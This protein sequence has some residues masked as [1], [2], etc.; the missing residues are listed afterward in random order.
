MP[1]AIFTAMIVLALV[2]VV[3]PTRAAAFGAGNIPSLSELEDHAFRHGDIEDILAHIALSS[4]A[5][6]LIS[7][8][9]KGLDIKR[10]YFGN[11]LRDYS[12][13]I[14]VGALSKVN[15]QTLMT[16][17]T[18]LGFLAFN[19]V[20]EEF[21]VTEQRLG[22]YRAEEH[23][24]NP[25]GYPEDAQSYDSRLRGPVNPRELEIDPRTGLKNYIA[26]EQGGWAT[27]T[28][29]VRRSIEMSVQAARNNDQY[30]AFRCL[31]QALHTLEDYPAHSN[32]VELCLIELG[33]NR[34][35]PFVGESTAI[36]QG[37]NGPIYPVITGTFGAADFV[38]SLLG[39]AT[40]HAS[41]ASI[42]NV[43]AKL[44]EAESGRS[45]GDDELLNLL[46][47]VPGMDDFSR[48]IR[49]DERTR[50][51]P[52]A[53]PEQIRGEIWKWLVLRDQ[54][55]KKVDQI[56]ASIPGLEWLTEKISEAIQLFIWGKLEP[57]LRPMISEVVSK[58]QSAS[59]VIVGQD[60]QMEV[61]NNP[62]CTDP[63]HS[64][65]S[66]DHFDLYLNEPA[67]KVAKYI[68]QNVVPAVVAAWS[69]GNP[70]DAVRM[71]MEVFV[72]PADM[73]FQKS[74]FQM[75]MINVVREWA[76][77]N[78]DAINHLDKGSVMAGRNKKHPT[79]S[80][81]DMPPLSALPGQ[82]GLTQA[83]GRSGPGG[84]ASWQQ[85]AQQPQ[86]QQQQQQG[87]GQGQG[88]SG[89]SQA[90]TQSQY[91]EG[92]PSGGTAAPS[93]PVQPQHGQGYSGGGGFTGMSQQPPVQ[94]QYV[95]GYPGGGPQGGPGHHHGGGP[96]GGGGGPHHHHQQQNEGGY[97]GSGSNSYF[98][99]GP[100]PPQ[101]SNYFEGYPGGAPSNSYYQNPPQQGY[102]PPP[103]PP[104]PQ[105]YGFAPPPGPPPPQGY[106]GPGFAPPEPGPGQPH[107]YYGTA[108]PSQGPPAP[109][110]GYPGGYPGNYGR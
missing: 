13:A 22:C 104:P 33:Y 69:S 11:W 98:Q 86:Y 38:H 68:V 14:D 77:A 3:F 92:W 15:K 72:H 20:T 97:P 27:S 73:G 88:Y 34:V 75:G 59:S 30:E 93:R 9:F 99:S 52:N 85:P 54:I 64:V 19:Y 41:Q 4:G 107:G 16:L 32:F 37:R 50:A 42:T 62:R 1:S 35:F 23:I 8:K 49:S 12:Q 7:K 87:Y 74:Q 94:S 78:R 91:V 102:A 100:P 51:A 65:L 18:V 6:G 66:K 40:D 57:Y 90:P 43:N 55:V 5:F 103:G 53:S 84:G 61:F 89:V 45:V 36:R 24:D 28:A 108:R 96:Q 67:G 109:Y 110:G 39:E 47:Q 29:Y 79:G 83:P 95:E 44:A 2:C 60:T 81:G 106:G 21:E 26:N 56:I 10:V 48:E 58:L 105:G 101:Q 71:A 25:K 17:V 82:L 46:G 80:I 31:G 76:N 63:T 70:S